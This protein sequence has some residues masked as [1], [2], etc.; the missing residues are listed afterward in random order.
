MQGSGTAAVEAM[1]NTVPK[2]GKACP[3]GERA[4]TATRFTAILGMISYS[5]DSN[6]IIG[7]LSNEL[8]L[9]VM[10]Y[11]NISDIY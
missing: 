1:L 10:I 3:I 7:N 5:N 9:I 11:S 6:D 4:E 2:D 8:E